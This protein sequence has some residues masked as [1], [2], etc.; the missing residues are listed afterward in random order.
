VGILAGVAVSAR[1]QEYFWVLVFFMQGVGC[2][3]YI[4]LQ[5]QAL[6]R[7]TAGAPGPRALCAML[8]ASSVAMVAFAIVIYRQSRRER[9]NAYAQVRDRMRGFDLAWQALQAAGHDDW[10]ALAARSR[11]VSAALDARRARAR[12]AARARAA[13]ALGLRP[14]WAAGRLRFAGAGKVR[15]QEQDL[16]VLYGHAEEL[17][18]R[19]QLWVARWSPVGEVVYAAVKS[20]DRAVQKTVRSYRREPA[21]L[22]DLVR[23]SVAVRSPCDARRAAP[24]GRRAVRCEA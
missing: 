17:S 14:P 8:L 7:A 11:S 16:E 12:G 2:A 21:L 18:A 19:F 9:R 23:C 13:A 6:D 20:P 3:A 24:E 15:Q 10:R 4:G 5:W 1:K 22:T